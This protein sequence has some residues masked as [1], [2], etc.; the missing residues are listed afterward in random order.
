MYM[1]YVCTYVTAMHSATHVR[2]HI[3]CIVN[4]Y[5]RT[6]ITDLC[7]KKCIYTYVRPP[8]LTHNVLTLEKD[9]NGGLFL[10]QQ[11]GN[12][13]RIVQQYVCAG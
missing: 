9:T 3:I 11:R 1:L 6:C 7:D 8:T 12:H 5:I 10:T 4:V 13:K 2:L